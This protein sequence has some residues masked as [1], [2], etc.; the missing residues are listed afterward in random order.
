M[1]RAVS[2]SASITRV[3]RDTPGSAVRPT[4]SDAMLKPR[5][6]NSD[7]IRLSTPGLS[8]TCAIMV[9][10]ATVCIVCISGV[11]C[12]LDQRVMGLGAAD[13]LGEV[14]ARRHHRVDRI[15]LLDAEV[16]HDGAG[17]RLRRAH[18]AL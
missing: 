5:R 13:H 9:W 15:L 10:V 7:A 16:D 11:L 14:G 18:G 4:V 8:S 2:S 12:G 3:S 1:R 6:R 17:G